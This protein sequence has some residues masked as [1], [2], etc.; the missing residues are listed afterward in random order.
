VSTAVIARICNNVRST[1]RMMNKPATCTRTGPRQHRLARRRRGAAPPVSQET[2]CAFSPSSLITTRLEKRSA[3][4]SRAFRSATRRSR[5]SR[6][7]RGKCNGCAPKAA[8]TTPRTTL[9]N[10]KGVSAQVSGFVAFINAARVCWLPRQFGPPAVT[11]RASM[12]R[13]GRTPNGVTF[14]P[15]NV[16][17][18][19]TR[20]INVGT[21]RFVS[22]SVS[23]EVLPIGVSRLRTSE[24]G[25]ATATAFG[26]AAESRAGSCRCEE[27]ARALATAGA[28]R[29]DPKMSILPTGGILRPNGYRWIGIY[30]G[31]TTVGP[32]VRERGH[33]S[34]G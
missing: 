34:H 31:T 26:S 12:D 8:K 14:Q 27:P 2:K 21:L 5:S 4:P 18:Y 10:S 7:L 11:R 33:Q 19:S 16:A 23:R 30:G 15:I 13:R 1:I 29:R 20:S 17:T 6:P 22:S 28:A 25:G 3:L 9:A 32:V 24:A